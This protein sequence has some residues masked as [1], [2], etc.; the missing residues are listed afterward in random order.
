[1]ITLKRG[2]LIAYRAHPDGTFAQHAVAAILIRRDGNRNGYLLPLVA[3]HCTATCH[4]N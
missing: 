4:S 3:A 2:T 1:M